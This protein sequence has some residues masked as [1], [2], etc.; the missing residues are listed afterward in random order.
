MEPVYRKAYIELDRPDE[1][2]KFFTI[3]AEKLSKES[4]EG[5]PIT[6][7]CRPL[8]VVYKVRSAL[9]AR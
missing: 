1:R 7:A 9:Y 4:R 3:E 2:L 6:D 5:L 8:F